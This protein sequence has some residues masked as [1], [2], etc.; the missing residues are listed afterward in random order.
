MVEQH[1]LGRNNLSPSADIVPMCRQP[2]SVSVSA[3]CLLN[4][5]RDNARANGGM[6]KWGQLFNQRYQSERGNICKK[7]TSMAEG[8]AFSQTL[9]QVRIIEK[10]LQ[11][12]RIEK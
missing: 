7:D 12:E 2:S 9:Y 5:G 4:N 6:V 1:R 10:K 3:I 8:W 11:C